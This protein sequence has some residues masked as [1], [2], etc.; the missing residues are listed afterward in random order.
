[1]N[2][3]RSYPRVVPPTLSNGHPDLLH[4]VAQSI[5]VKKKQAKKDQRDATK[6]QKAADR[7]AKKAARQKRDNSVV[8]EDGFA[9]YFLDSPIKAWKKL[10]RKGDVVATYTCQNGEWVNQASVLKTAV[11]GNLLTYADWSD[12]FFPDPQERGIRVCWY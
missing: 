2:H 5:W 12:P 10:T 1:M 4:T 3:G 7:E 11:N 9:E 6:A 8:G